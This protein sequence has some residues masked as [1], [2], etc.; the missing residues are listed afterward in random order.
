MKISPLTL[1]QS[2]LR[3]ERRKGHTFVILLPIDVFKIR[4]YFKVN[5]S[6]AEQVKFG[7]YLQFAALSSCRPILWFVFSKCGQK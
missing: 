4:I 2:T 1:D 5:K 3:F 6:N 7:V